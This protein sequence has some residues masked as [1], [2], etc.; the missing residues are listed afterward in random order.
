MSTASSS[1]TFTAHSSGGELAHPNRSAIASRSR[2][3]NG[4][5]HTEATGP[6]AENR[7]D[8]ARHSGISS[9]DNRSIPDMTDHIPVLTACEQRPPEQ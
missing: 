2:S 4:P 9:G 8:N 1:A 5:T 3:V 7:S 6:P